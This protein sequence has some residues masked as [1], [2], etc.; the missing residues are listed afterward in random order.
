MWIDSH[1]HLFDLSPDHLSQTISE[2]RTHAVD[3][4]INVGTDL[5]TSGI[6]VSQCTSYPSTLVAAVGISPFDVTGLDENWD[7]QLAGLLQENCVVAVGETGLDT[8]NPSYP[9]AALQRP[10][11]SRQMELADQNDVPIVLHSRGAEQQVLDLCLEKGIRKAVF[12]CYTGPSKVLSEIVRAGYYVSFSGIATFKRSPVPS[13]IAQTPVERLLI[14]TDSPYL[15]PVPHR[16]KQN[17][18]AWVSH[19]GSKAAEIKGISAEELA[20]HIRHNTH[21]LFDRLSRRFPK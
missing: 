1:A 16:G 12:H 9:D 13:L 18:P 4:V 17:R 5:R 2:T 14:E 11:L 19:V 7:V 8:S 6:V 20:D 21:R 3:L 15:A 10:V